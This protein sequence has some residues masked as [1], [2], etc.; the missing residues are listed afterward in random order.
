[1]RK[2]EGRGDQGQTKVVL[3]LDRKVLERIK[4]KVWKSVVKA[5]IRDG[6]CENEIGG[7]AGGSKAEDV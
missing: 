1:M 4:G 6:D 2:S 7:R 3:G 5:T